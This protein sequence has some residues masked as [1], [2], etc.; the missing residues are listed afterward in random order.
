MLKGL[1]N[2]AK[3]LEDEMSANLVLFQEILGLSDCLAP[4]P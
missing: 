3:A 1:D 2:R 4:N